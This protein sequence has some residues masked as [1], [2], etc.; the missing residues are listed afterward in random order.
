MPPISRL[1]QNRLLS[2]LSERSLAALAPELEEV[3]LSLDQVLIHSGGPAEHL[4]FVLD[5]IVSLVAS[6]GEDQAEVGCVGFE[7]L[8]GWWELLGVSN[9]PL[10][11]FVQSAGSALRIR[12]SVLRDCAQNDPQLRDLLLRYCYCMTVQVS[13]TAL[14]NARFTIGER[15]ARWLLMSQDRIRSDD[16]PLKHAFLALMLGVRRS[17]VTDALHLIEGVGFIKATRVNI[18]VLDRGGLEQLAGGSYGVPE[19]EYD[20]VMAGIEYTL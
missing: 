19:A 2:L 12:T 11:T 6:G 4:H 17:G 16:L 10:Q 20:R 13:Y 15:L 14:A 9:V 18:R 3:S 1:H 8:T 7:G 5:G